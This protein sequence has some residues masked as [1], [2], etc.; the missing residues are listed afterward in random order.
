[1]KYQL[2]QNYNYID[3]QNMSNIY[4]IVFKYRG[5]FLASLVNEGVV[6]IENNKVE[7]LF[8][9]VPVKD[10]LFN[11]YGNIKMTKIEAYDRKYKKIKIIKKIV[12]DEIQLSNEVWST[13]TKNIETFNKTNRYV[14]D[15][16]TYIEYTYKNKTK[17]ASPLVNNLRSKDLPQKYKNK[18]QKLRNDYG[19]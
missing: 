15:V 13:S 1:M 4:R 2:T 19:T 9:T 7:I 16:K 18:L 11:Y 17:C 6:F 3:I 14:G 5:A 8:P 12:N 10:I